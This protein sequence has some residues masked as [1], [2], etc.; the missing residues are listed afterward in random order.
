MVGNVQAGPR[1]NL[2]Q[3]LASGEAWHM[4]LLGAVTLEE[5]METHLGKGDASSASVTS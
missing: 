4:R 5:E 3:C 1:S 2:G